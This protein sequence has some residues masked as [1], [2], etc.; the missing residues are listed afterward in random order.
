[1]K[2]R[3]KLHKEQ[4]CNY[5]TESIL[6]SLHKAMFALKDTIHAVIVFWWK[7]KNLTHHLLKILSLPKHSF[8]YIPSI[9]FSTNSILR[10]STR[11]DRFFVRVTDSARLTRR[12]IM[13]I[14][15]RF[16]RCTFYTLHCDISGDTWSTLRDHALT[17]GTFG[18]GKTFNS[19]SARDSQLIPPTAS[20]KRYLYWKL[21]M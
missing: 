1:M 3:T 15:V 11:S 14:R 16:P 19:F 9:A 18:T 8:V 2:V 12:D 17:L 7:R 13:L 4:R 20:A 5:L 6:R 21:T 10:S